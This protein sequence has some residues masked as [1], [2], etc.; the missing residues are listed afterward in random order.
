MLQNL[1]Y[2]FSIDWKSGVQEDY[3]FEKIAILI[4]MRRLHNPVRDL[5]VKL[6]AIQ[7]KLR[8]LITFTTLRDITYKIE[9]GVGKFLRKNQV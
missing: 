2:F 7:T 6:R 4:R 8:V 9:S 1:F 3:N 5:E